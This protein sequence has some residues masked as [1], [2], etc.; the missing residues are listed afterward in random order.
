M[1]ATEKKR[2]MTGITSG[3]VTISEATINEAWQYL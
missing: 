1:K 3:E 2:F